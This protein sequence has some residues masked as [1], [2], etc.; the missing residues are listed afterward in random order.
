M[1]AG[2]KF[3]RECGGGSGVASGVSAPSLIPTS[4]ATA[5]IERLI[6]TVAAE[7]LPS[8]QPRSKWQRWVLLGVGLLAAMILGGTLL[9]RTGSRA[10]RSNAEAVPTDIA[11]LLPQGALIVEQA[12]LSVAVGKPRALVLWMDKPER[13]LR[14]PSDE[15][16]SC[17]EQTTGNYFSGPTRLSLIELKQGALLNTVKVLSGEK[18]ENK[19]TFSIPFLIKRFY[20]D[21]PDLDVTQLGKPKILNL[22]DY[23]GDGAATE[24][25]LYDTTEEACGGVNTSLL[26]Y[27]AKTDTVIQY[28]T[29]TTDESGKTGYSVWVEGVFATKS[30]RPGVWNYSWSPGHGSEAVIHEEVSYDPGKEVFLRKVHSFANDIEEA[31]AHWKDFYTAF[32]SAVNKQDRNGILLM[33][34]GDFSDGGGGLTASEWLQFIDKNAKNGSWRDLQKSFAQGTIINKDR[35]SNG[36]PIRVTKDNGHYFEFRKKTGWCF[37]GVVGD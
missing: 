31:D 22:A 37:A 12:D 13:N 30:I 15:S 2:A 10:A 14:N 4:V 36:T 11:K 21:V 16:Y 20:Y 6:L 33:M 27:S 3:C 7:V 32:L 5:P 29:F 25:A 18:S 1:V 8:P 34:P 28:P 35:S 19:D 9:S 23:N 17:Q 26:G 24:F